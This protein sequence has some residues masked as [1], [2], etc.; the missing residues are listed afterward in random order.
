MK[1]NLLLP[2]TFFFYSFSLYAQSNC[3]NHVKINLCPVAY[4]ANETNLAKGD[5]A[6]APCNITGE[7][8]VYEISAPAA[9]QKIYVSITNA[10]ASL[11]LSLEQTACGNGVCNQQTVS[12]GN[13][14]TTFTVSAATVYF[15]WV[16][17]SVTVTYNIS[18]G[19]DTGS[20][21]VNIPNTQGNLQ[22]DNSGC[23]A[24]P[25]MPSKPFLQVTY[26]SIYKTNP[27]TLS[28]LGVP[29][30]MCIIVFFKNTTGIEAVKKCTF[31]F[32]VTGY[33]AI[34]APA[35]IPGFYNA[36]NWIS[37]NI[38][39][40][41]TFQ[42]FDAAA[43]GKGDFTGT[44]NTCLRYMFCFTLTPL[45][46]NPAYTN[47]KDTIVSDG[48]GAGFTGFIHHG[49]CPAANANCLGSGGPASNA[50]SF[51]A[52]FA[53]PGVLPVSLADFEAEPK[54]NKVSVTW[55]TASETNNDYFTVEKSVD[56]ENWAV[57]DQ[58]K[59]AGT[60]TSIRR[61]Q[62]VD[63]KPYAATSYYRLMQTDFNGAFSY[64]ET[65]KVYNSQPAD[66]YIYPNPASNFLTVTANGIS[67]LDFT[68]YNIM[69]EKVQLPVTIRSGQTELDVSHLPSGLYLLA[70]EQDNNTIKKERIIIQR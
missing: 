29:G 4:L 18:I 46:N 22:F 5:D 28:P 6:P 48:F 23:A 57:V 24:P 65:R 45:S 40:V 63:E 58:V 64:S 53:D 36:G 42:F 16:D 14:N 17:A 52:S 13:S 34:S 15:L 43:T 41:W 30:N 66:I 59:G 20:V 50:H 3:A 8:V 9:T 51:G 67:N 47:V 25:F 21:W 39:N 2:A 27:M 10:T 49:C 37:S 33:S 55:T 19:G 54:N 68:F 12:S 26:N 62:V 11:K 69:G 31:Y 44:P 70:I 7:D 35:S 60:S 32:P 56:T 61:Y 38:G 1:K